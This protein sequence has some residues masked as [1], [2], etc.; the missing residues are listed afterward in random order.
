MGYLSFVMVPVF[1]IVAAIA[2]PGLLH[3]RIV[4]NESSAVGSIRTIYVA[5]V[6]YATSYPAVGYTCSLMDLGGTGRPPS[7]KSAGLIDSV[8]ASGQKIGYRFTLRNCSGN[9]AESYQVTAEPIQRGQT[10][11]RTFCSDQKGVI[12]FSSTGTVE[13]CLSSG[14]PIQ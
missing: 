6:T 5:E 9:P 4:V 13:E 14:T 7:E 2:I 12:S 8:L 10:G 3:S 1:L 11:Q